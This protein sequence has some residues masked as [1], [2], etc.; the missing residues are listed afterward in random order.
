M[1]AGW[2]DQYTRYR[3][4]FLNI[5]DLYKKR[6]DLR[7]F[8]E[9]I[10]S[11]TTI[12]IFISFALKPTVLTIIS[13]NQ[14][15]QE[16]ERTLAALEEKNR[17][18]DLANELLIQNQARVAD[19]NASVGTLPNPETVSKQILG[20][21]TKNN[22]TLLGLSIGQATIVGVDPTGQRPTDF[23]PIEGAGGEMTISISA[24]GDFQSINSF[25][26]DIEN[27]RIAIKVDS[28]TV[29]SSVTEA[30]QVI[31]AVIAGRVPYTNI[32]E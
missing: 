1:A 24:R 28:L 20:V 19:I 29:N 32:P 25:V 27:L 4:F 23:K 2:R 22:T 9:V 26:G 10:L 14:Q 3:G 31:I 21:A 7:A 12:V 5:R 18:L 11:L 13:L 17:N 15:I 8:F 6:A 30:G 16:K